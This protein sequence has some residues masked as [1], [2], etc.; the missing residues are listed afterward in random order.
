MAN[1]N[2]FIDCKVFEIDNKKTL[3]AF[4]M[5]VARYR[6]LQCEFVEFDKEGDT[7]SRALQKVTVFLD[8]E[9]ALLLADDITSGRFFKKAQKALDAATEK[10]SKYAEAIFQSMGGTNEEKCKAKGLRTDGKAM[11][12]TV[13]ITP[14][15]YKPTPFVIT[16]KQGAGESNA[17]GL[18]VP[19][20]GNN[21]E[22]KVSVSCTADTLRTLALMMDKYI[23]AYIAK[24]LISG[25]YKE[26]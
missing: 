4:K 24:T 11:S 16:A 9:E 8:F 2:R 12:R 17:Q 7:G 20:Y 19:K 21:P 1:T 18:I 10:N 3:V 13:T 22:Q 25:E 23:S 26:L 5:N 14:S 15:F 6:K